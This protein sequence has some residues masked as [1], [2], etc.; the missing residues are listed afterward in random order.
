MKRVTIYA[1]VSTKEQSVDMQLIDLRAYA[2]RRGLKL[3]TN[4]STM[5]VAVRMIAKI[6]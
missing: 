4:T 6:T 1:H 3:S 5:R 2:L